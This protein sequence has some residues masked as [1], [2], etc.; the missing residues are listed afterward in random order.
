[1]TATPCDHCGEVH[2]HPPQANICGR[3]RYDGR[4]VEAE[5]R[6]KSLGPGRGC[7]ALVGARSAPAGIR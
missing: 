1:M 5:Q 2:K 4:S 7:V 3:A 6:E